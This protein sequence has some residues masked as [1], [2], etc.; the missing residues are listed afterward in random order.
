MA[1]S[2][3]GVQ[4]EK[5]WSAA[6]L[7]L[8]DPLPSE[9]MNPPMRVFGTVIALALS[10][11]ACTG[12]D[13]NSTTT[14]AP[15]TT[16]STVATTRPVVDPDDFSMDQLTN[17]E[18][19]EWI[20]ALTSDLV[21][22]DVTSLAGSVYVL[23]TSPVDGGLQGW[24]TS[25]GANWEELGQIVPSGSQVAA[26]GTTVDRI[27]VSTSPGPG[28]LPK[29]Y[30]T[31]DGVAWEVEEIPVELDN[32]FAHFDTMA[33]GGDET[34][35]VV[36]GERTV[37]VMS[38]VGERL[39]EIALEGFEITRESISWQPS[40]DDNL[41][42]LVGPMS[43][44][45]ASATGADI[46][47]SA[48]DLEM[49]HEPGRGSIDLWI[50]PTGGVW[51]SSAL[52]GTD[53]FSIAALPTG[54][55]VATGLIGQQGVGMWTSFEGL[56]WELAG[57]VERP[58]T[59]TQWRDVLLGPSSGDHGDLILSRDGST[60]ER[61]GL[62]QNFPAVPDWFVTHVGTADSG[63]V[64]AVQSFDFPERGP[65]AE[66]KPPVIRRDGLTV[67]P[68]SA[69]V[70]IAV[71]GSDVV[72]SFFSTNPSIEDSLEIDLS[73]GT[74]TFFT[75]EGDELLPLTIEELWA[76]ED[77][78]S[79]IRFEGEILG[80]ALAFSADTENW[81]IWDMRDIDAGIHP[82]FV[83]LAGDVAIVV[84]SDGTG[85][86]GFKVWTASLR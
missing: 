74:F 53:V 86:P 79:R 70:D 82:D 30:T 28:E 43:F 46:G 63:V 85:A 24:R 35:I 2:V 5:S 48:Q 40:G 67:T 51:Q 50:K 55:L 45:L 13:A 18:T 77:E 33:L 42:K 41:Y 27:L 56:T 68:N 57:F 59:L 25:D 52:N 75:P 64:A 76:L 47:L 1:K 60:W 61:T 78:W 9:A 54:Q 11:G 7:S 23:S 29:V 21:P 6:H 73:A 44:V 31:S 17:G 8:L 80:Q 16:S 65:S 38:V 15:P 36:A 32:V 66:F 84:T 83:A 81:T 10:T 14:T 49:L 72:Y 22:V 71:D 34:Q 12:S 69:G 4:L 26:I 3:H 20:E 19:L 39:A 62:T 58:L 37:D